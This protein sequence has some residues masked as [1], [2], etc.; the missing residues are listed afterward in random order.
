MAGLMVNM[1]IG[2]PNVAVF[3]YFT[4]TC[5]ITATTAVNSSQYEGREE[6]K[7]K[8]SIQTRQQTSKEKMAR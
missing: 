7:T 2:L 4:V 8:F 3:Q 6:K 5:I 1:G